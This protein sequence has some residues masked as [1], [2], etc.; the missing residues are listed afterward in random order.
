MHQGREDHD[1]EQPEMTTPHATELPASNK[2]RDE[3]KDSVA[4]DREWEYEQLPERIRLPLANALKQE[5]LNEE[6]IHR[7]TGCSPPDSTRAQNHIGRDSA[8]A[9]LGEAEQSSIGVSASQQYRQVPLMLEDSSRKTEARRSAA[10][11]V[12]DLVSDSTQPR[13][14]ADDELSKAPAPREEAQ[15]AESSSS[16]YNSAMDHQLWQENEPEDKNDPVD[17]QDT[18]SVVGVSEWRILG[19]S[20]RGR[21]HAHEGKYREDAFIGATEGGWHFVAVADGAGSADLS[22]VGATR[23]VQAALESIRES[24]R[25]RDDEAAVA[26]PDTRQAVADA[27]V[28][29]LGDAARALEQE[30]QHRSI[31]IR[32]LATTLLILAHQP[33]LEG[34]CVVTAQV[35]DGCIAAW[36]S[37]RHVLALGKP[38]H[39][40]FAGETYFLTSMSSDSDFRTRVHI[41]DEVAP[42]VSLFLVMTDGVADDFFPV[43]EQLEKLIRELP[44]VLEVENR[45]AED[46]LLELLAYRKRASFDDRTLVVLASSDA[47]RRIGQANARDAK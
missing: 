33:A 4:D 38:E 12:T 24:L 2:E 22:R 39:G 45:E 37:S 5:G 14:G 1:Q 6:A 28:D 25:E 42:D 26:S 35:G 15:P 40:R 11:G 17:H 9:G 44:H 41:E 7:I 23:A 20:R 34:H 21:L 31:P 10:E 29:A 16:S 8:E 27:L 36:S 46:R 43:D 18:L 32:D 19:V 30:A 3:R 47:R 13:T